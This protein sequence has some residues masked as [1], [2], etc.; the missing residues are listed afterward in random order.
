M[1]IYEPHVKQKGDL[2]NTKRVLEEIDKL[3]EFA[4]PLKPDELKLNLFVKKFFIEDDDYYNIYDN[5]TEYLGKFCYGMMSRIRCIRFDIGLRSNI[6]NLMYYNVYFHN[7]VKFICKD[8]SKSRVHVITDSESH[9]I[10]D[11]H[12]LMA[13]FDY[14]TAA[15]NNYGDFII[16]HIAIIRSKMGITTSIKRNE[17]INGILIV[18]KDGNK[19][20]TF[21]ENCSKLY[22]TVSIRLK[23]PILIADNYEKIDNL[24]E[25]LYDGD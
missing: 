6:K 14:K 25:L 4:V 15:R 3:G 12:I 17:D 9:N 19:Y 10:A 21:V 8:V 2:S 16:S 7:K 22:K 11:N 18:N 5:Y 24:L 23:H 13:Y 1:L 20:D